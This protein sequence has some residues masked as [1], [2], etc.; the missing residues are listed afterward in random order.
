MSDPQKVFVVNQNRLIFSI[1]GFEVMATIGATYCLVRGMSGVASDIVSIV[2]YLSPLLITTIP[3]I[4][5]TV[6]EAVVAGLPKIVGTLTKGFT[7]LLPV[8]TNAIGQI[9]PEITKALPEVLGTLT[10]AARSLTTD[11]L[12][13]LEDSFIGPIVKPLN[14]ILEFL[15]VK[16]SDDHL[17]PVEKDIVKYEKDVLE[18]KNT[19]ALGGPFN[20]KTDEEIKKI[21]DETVERDKK[22]TGGKFI[23]FDTKILTF[24]G[25]T[26]YHNI[27]RNKQFPRKPREILEEAKNK[28][29]P[30]ILDKLD[31]GITDFYQTDFGKGAQNVIKD[32]GNF[33]INPFKIFG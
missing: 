33:F 23:T 13:S 25:W 26:F 29:E 24:D 11:I 16:K 21:H 3:Q 27:P 22:E 7:T 2:E 14:G 15:G 6:L 32:I 8:I 9:I 31:K 19:W 1:T 5:Q 10:T 30:N 28:P 20:D 17:T 18:L 12:N 4:I